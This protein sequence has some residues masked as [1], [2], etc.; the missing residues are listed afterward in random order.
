MGLNFGA[1]V[2]LGFWANLVGFWGCF[3]TIFGWGWLSFWMGSG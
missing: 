2:G 1:G 3:G